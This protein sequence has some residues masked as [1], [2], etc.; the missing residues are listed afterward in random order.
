MNDTKEGIEERVKKVIEFQLGTS[1]LEIK[2]DARIIDDLGADSLDCAELIMAL[3]DE[4]NIE[5]SDE[6]AEQCS[7]VQSIINTI[8]NSSWVIKPRPTEAIASVVKVPSVEEEVESIM[9][10]AYFFA[11]G[12]EAA[13]RDPE[14]HSKSHK[15]FKDRIRTLVEASRK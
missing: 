4:F 12:Y 10:Q 13:A 3:E 15:E 8:A 14:A 5:V 7:T 9:L 6:E 2:N 1:R 11:V